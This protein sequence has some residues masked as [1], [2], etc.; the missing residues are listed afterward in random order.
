MKV[1]LGKK[2]S[3]TDYY[4]IEIETPLEEI[5]GPIAE[6]DVPVQAYASG[7][8]YGGTV[9]EIRKYTYNFVDLDFDPSFSTLS[10]YNI[11]AQTGP[12]TETISFIVGNSLSVSRT[13]MKRGT[14]YI[15]PI[16]D[17]F[18]DAASARDRQRNHFLRTSPSNPSIQFETEDIT[19]V[20]RLDIYGSF[21]RTLYELRNLILSEEP[22]PSFSEE[23]R[24]RLVGNYFQYHPNGNLR[25]VFSYRNSTM[26]GDSLLEGDYYE[27]YE[28]GNTKVIAHFTA[29]FL[30]GLYKQFYSNGILQTNCVI[31]NGKLQGQ[32]NQYTIEGNR[33]F[34]AFYTNGT[35]DGSYALD[36]Q[37]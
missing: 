18:G 30:N 21:E 33:E 34:I 3:P 13:Y 32:Y 35:L 17:S 8:I 27:Y 28:N 1:Y 11:V 5:G 2:T 15:G 9:T 10:S 14:V 16:L 26:T 22:I 19:G 23:A 29:N 25:Q 12:F 37:L 7:F 4:V 31:V 24:D 20:K 6:D 36:Y